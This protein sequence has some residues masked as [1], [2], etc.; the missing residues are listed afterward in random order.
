MISMGRITLMCC[1]GAL[2]GGLSAPCD[3]GVSFHHGASN[4]IIV[5]GVGD[6]GSKMESRFTHN[7]YLL[8]LF[9]LS[10]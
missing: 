1:L 9:N 4:P 6:S 10:H 3:Y 2:I 7:H 8:L 5:G